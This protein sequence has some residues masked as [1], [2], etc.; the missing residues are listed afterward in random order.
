MFPNVLIEM[1]R[2][3]YSQKKMAEY[4]GVSKATL[5]NK[6]NGK[7]QFTLQEMRAMKEALGVRSLDYLFEEYKKEE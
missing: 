1:K 3:G 6:L 4:I 5:Q 7:T 2:R